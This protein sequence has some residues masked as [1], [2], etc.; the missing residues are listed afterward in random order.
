M[1]GFIDRFVS[2]PRLQ[3]IPQR[4]E[5]QSEMV[6]TEET[7]VREGEEWLWIHLGGI[8][9]RIEPE[10]FHRV[11]IDACKKKSYNPSNFEMAHTKMHD[12]LQDDLSGENAAVI[13]DFSLSTFEDTEKDSALTGLR[14]ASTGVY[15]CQF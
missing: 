2:L 3:T 10:Y 15:T 11:M 8:P 7:L 6:A 5:S 9:P 12:I 4:G 13:D 14:G 1:V